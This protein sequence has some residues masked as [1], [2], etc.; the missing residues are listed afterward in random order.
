[1]TRWCMPTQGSGHGTRQFSFE[2][3]LVSIPRRTALE[4]NP[5]AS[6]S[7]PPILP[8]LKVD[9]TTDYTDVTDELT[10]RIGFADRTQSVKF[11]SSVVYVLEFEI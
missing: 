8:N 10:Q 2:C 6:Y 3:A 5:R 7:I 11:V 1:M 4:R 9:L